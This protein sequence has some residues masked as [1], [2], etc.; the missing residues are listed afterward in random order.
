MSAAKGLRERVRG[1]LRYKE[2]CIINLWEKIGWAY[3]LLDDLG[4]AD[5]C[6][7]TQARFQPGCADAYI[8]LGWFYESSELYKQAVKVYLDGLNHC[9]GDE[10]LS[11]N[12]AQLLGRMGMQDGAIGGHSHE[13]RFAA[14]GRRLL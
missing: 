4:K 13:R 9:P 11:F 3:Y 5:R 12:L 10:Y 2:G 6:L 1:Y 14:G 8:N 7:R